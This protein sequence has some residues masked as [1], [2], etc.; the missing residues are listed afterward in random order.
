MRVGEQVRASGFFTLESFITNRPLRE[1]E[2]LLGFHEGR[3]SEGIVVVAFARLPAPHE[4]ALDAYS[5]LNAELGGNS[6]AADQLKRELI[7]G[8]RDFGPRR[9]VKVTPVKGRAERDIDYRPG[10][11]APQWKAVAPI[12]ARI[13]AVIDGY[14]EESDPLCLVF[15]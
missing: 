11:G 13:V 14:T 7:S 12:P 10:I 4:F 15:P 3:F 6:G 5:N 9:L 8:W 2:P 1:L